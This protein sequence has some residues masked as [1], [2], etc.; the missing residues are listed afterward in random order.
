MTRTTPKATVD[1]FWMLVRSGLTPSAAGVAVGVSD[2]TGRRVFNNAGGVRPQ[3]SQLHTTGPRPRLTLWE[4][5]K[6]QAGVERGDSLRRIAAGLDRAPSTIK[7]ELD[8]NVRNRYDGRK[9][10]YRRKE[11]FG[12]RQSGNTSV[13]HYDALAAQESAHRRTRRPKTRKLAVA[14]TLRREVQT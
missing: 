12:A 10:G 5:I 9:S 8:N 11:A 4:R 7:R 2:L 1:E 3:L 14:G 13:V 6:I